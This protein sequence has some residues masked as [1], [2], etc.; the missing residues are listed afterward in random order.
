MLNAKAQPIHRGEIFEDP[1]DEILQ[2]KKL[3]EVCGGGTA[4]S[5]IGEVEH[6]DIEI[7]LFDKAAALEVVQI[8]ESLGAPKGSRLQFGNGTDPDIEFGRTE[9]L[10]L[11]LNGTDLADTVYAECDSNVVFDQISTLIEG[12]GGILS[13]WQGATEAALYLYGDS[14]EL[15]QSRIHDFVS[16]YPLCEKCRIV[17]IA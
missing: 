12:C 2:R 15:M 4:I 11:Y 1:L 14:F 10:G 8:L 6:G 9:G 17:R 16:T 7:A 5:D 3:G 13:H